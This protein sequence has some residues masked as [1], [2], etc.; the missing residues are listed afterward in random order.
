MSNL[1]TATHHRSG[2][3]ISNTERHLTTRFLNQWGTPDCVSFD[4]FVAEY[5]RALEGS[6]PDFLKAAGN[7]LIDHH[8]YPMR[9]PTVAECRAIVNEI[10]E[11]RAHRKAALAL[12]APDEVIPTPEQRERAAK[13]MERVVA[14]LKVGGE[15]MVARTSKVSRASP[16]EQKYAESGVKL[17]SG[18]CD[19]SRNAFENRPGKLF[20]EHPAPKLSELGRPPVEENNP[21]DQDF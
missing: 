7:H 18:W 15:T 4:A 5:I 3:S 11:E 9:W 8:A 16:S 20:Q 19:T 10:A 12:P 13:L 17:A 1:S 2:R 21:H 6:D 14:N